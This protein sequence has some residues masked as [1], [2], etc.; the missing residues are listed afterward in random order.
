LP[1]ITGGEFEPIDRHIS[2]LRHRNW[3]LWAIEQVA[4][5][6]LDDLAMG[7]YAAYS[8]GRQ[9]PE[10]ARVLSEW[11]DTHHIE[12][13]EWLIDVAETTIEFWWR[14]PSSVTVG[15]HW[16]FLPIAWFQVVP[17]ELRELCFEL[18]DLLSETLEPFQVREAEPG[19]F[20]RKKL[21]QG[22]FNRRKWESK[23][24]RASSNGI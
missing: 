6:V 14:N 9:D 5:N 11:A 21:S 22:N 15:R 10:F 8:K 7:P 13:C 20:T 16:V 12:G 24:K 3:F 18:P 4:P 1:T 23:L 17:I 2:E 19:K